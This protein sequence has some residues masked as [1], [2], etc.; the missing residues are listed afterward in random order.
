MGTKRGERHPP[1]PPP[2]LIGPAMVNAVGLSIKL[3]GVG[4]L[5]AHDRRGRKMIGSDSKYKTYGATS[6]ENLYQTR[7]F[8]F[9]RSTHV[10]KPEEPGFFFKNQTRGII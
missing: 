2:R 4:A 9:L 7:Y 1:S 6:Y 3:G 5:K 10:F 8:E